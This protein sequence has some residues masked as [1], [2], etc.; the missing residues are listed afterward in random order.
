MFDNSRRPWTNA[1]GNLTLIV[2]VIAV[3]SALYFIAVQVW[4]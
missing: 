3:L 4:S 1:P 2:V